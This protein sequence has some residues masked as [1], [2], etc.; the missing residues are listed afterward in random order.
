MKEGEILESLVHYREFTLHNG[1]F[2][3]F[4]KPLIRFCFLFDMTC[5]S[6]LLALLILGH[7][8]QSQSLL[9]IIP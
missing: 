5:I 6:V 8:D 2:C 7:N 1:I 4:H 9:Y 3:V